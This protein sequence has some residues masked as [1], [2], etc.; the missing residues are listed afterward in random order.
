M[1]AKHLIQKLLLSSLIVVSSYCN[2][3]I[4]LQWLEDKPRSTTKDFYIWQFLQQ[5]I[6]PQEAQ[7][8]L[9]EAKNVNMILFTRY[10]KKLHHEETNAIIECI[11]SQAVNLITQSSDC[12]ALGLT[13]SKAIS[14]DYNQKLQAIDI[15]KDT[16][17]DEATVLKVFN[18]PLPFTKLLATPPN[19]FFKI[20]NQSP[21]P[22]VE[23]FF[24]YR[25]STSLLDKLSSFEEFNQSIS[26][27]V[28]N[29]S[30]KNLQESLL[31]SFDTTKLNHQSLFFLALN[32]LQYE[33]N[34]LAIYYLE[35]ASKKAYSKRSKDK[36]LFWRYKI[37]QQNELLDELSN[38]LDINLYSLYA[39]EQLNKLPDNI[40]Y[41]INVQETVPSSFDTTNP[42]AWIE[43]LENLKNKSLEDI[44]EYETLFNTEETLPHLAYVYERLSKYQTFYFIT[45]YA[46][47]LESYDVKRQALIYALAKQ[48]SHFIPTAISHSYALGVMQIMP[49]LS[50]NIAEE[51]K[52]SYLI[53]DQFKPEINL[54]YAN[55]HLDYLEKHLVNPLYIAYAYNGGIGF[56]KR[57]IEKG[58][59]Q[60]E[61]PYEPFLSMELM[62]NEESREY[63][64]QVLA[65]YYIYINHLDK[66]NRTKLSTL[67]ENLQ[68]NFPK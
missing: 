31:A 10:A 37:T 58:F 63:G 26:R 5:D 9:G 8:A 47:Y 15:L 25:I 33:Q 13:P 55:Y 12:L 20:F 45:P 21:L 49:F 48:E 46:K 62:S 57:T 50:K 39:K 66:N 35:E 36:I 29:E 11:N 67:L 30:L 16:Y 60:K 14:L 1:Y 64:K 56:M 61:S 53:Y 17:P 40:E 41:T 52:E 54:K 34:E 2:E 68:H 6:T 44:Q 18:A 27:I 59:T 32:A 7:F 28:T 51:L 19:L 3:S 24:N 43:V 22:F 65:N 42:F 23:E 4:T 38:S